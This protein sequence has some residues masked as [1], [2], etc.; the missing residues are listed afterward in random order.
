MLNSV[1]LHKVLE[2]LAAETG[3]LS[4]TIISGWPRAVKVVLSL[5]IVIAEEAELVTCTSSR[6]E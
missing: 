3:P 6:F 1:S 2:F 4:E 5:A